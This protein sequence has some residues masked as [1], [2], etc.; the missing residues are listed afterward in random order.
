M[1]KTYKSTICLRLLTATTIFRLPIL[2]NLLQQG[3]FTLSNTL[4]YGRIFENTTL[5]TKGSNIFI[6]SKFYGLN[7]KYKVSRDTPCGLRYI[8]SNKKN[9]KIITLF[10]GRLPFGE[11]S[12]PKVS[13]PVNNMRYLNRCF[14]SVNLTTPYGNFNSKT[15]LYQPA[16]SFVNG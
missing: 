3:L 9:I 15:A 4:I 14:K 11:R 8:R 5:V 1:M 6:C 2:D 16:S 12:C 7:N 13:L 10:A